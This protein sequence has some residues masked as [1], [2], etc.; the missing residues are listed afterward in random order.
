MPLYIVRDK[1]LAP[2]LWEGW[3]MSAKLHKKVKTTKLLI[4][5]GKNKLEEPTIYPLPNLD[6]IS[7]RKLGS[8]AIDILSAFYVAKDNFICRER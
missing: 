2:T 6:G 4:K 7:E 5:K 1:M 3:M 8:S